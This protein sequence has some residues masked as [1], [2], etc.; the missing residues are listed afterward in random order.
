MEAYFLT[1]IGQVRN[2]NEDAGGIF[3]NKADQLL[4]I[5]ADGMSGHKGGEDASEIAKNIIKDNWKNLEKVD[6]PKMAEAWIEKTVNQANEAIYNKSK[7]TIDLEGMG[8][9]VVLAVC[10]EEY[11]TIAHVGDSRCYVYAENELKQVTEDHSFVNEL[12]RTGQISAN[13]AELHPGKN[14]LSRVLGTD[15]TVI[16]EIQTMAW[17]TGNKL[18]VC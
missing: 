3:Y 15:A 9:T 2:N 7:Q 5:I 8:T 6:N 1:D 16:T 4:A 14:V 17:E 18:L 10:T 12:I 13:D 11:V